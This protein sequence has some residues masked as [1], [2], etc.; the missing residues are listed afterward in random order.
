VLTLYVD[1][2]N[3]LNE[4]NVRWLD[5]NGLEGG[6]LG[7]PSAYYTGRRTSLGIKMTF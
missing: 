3:L 7:D 5:S 1:C 6:E 4:Q 2:R